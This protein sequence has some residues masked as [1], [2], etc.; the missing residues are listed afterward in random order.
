M[1]SLLPKT[2]IETAPEIDLARVFGGDSMATVSRVVK[3][4]SQFYFVAPK[5]FD[6]I[7]RPNFIVE[8]F[9]LFMPTRTAWDSEIKL[10]E[11]ILKHNSGAMSDDDIK[12]V[13]IEYLD[14]H[15]T[16]YHNGEAR[17]KKAI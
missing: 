2:Q 15:T 13:L 16:V 9:S 12:A 14:A 6:D 3:Y 5:S 8:D 11:A 1:P 4:I 10:C 7:S 17:A